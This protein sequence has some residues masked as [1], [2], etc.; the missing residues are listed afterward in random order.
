M[1]WEQQPRNGTPV[2]LSRH[3]FRVQAKCH[4]F[5]HIVRTS[6]LVSYYRA[7]VLFEPNTVNRTK[8]SDRKSLAARIRAPPPSVCPSR[9]ITA[10]VRRYVPHTVVRALFSPSVGHAKWKVGGLT[11]P[12]VIDFRP[13]SEPGDVACASLTPATFPFP[14]S[15]TPGARLIVQEV[16]GLS[17]RTKVSR[18][19]RSRC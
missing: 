1:R 11:L 8:P 19:R 16:R 9:R 14:G 7:G 13:T 3:K 4:Y 5:H 15:R 18:Y 6:P 2:H 12:T 10:Y 17:L